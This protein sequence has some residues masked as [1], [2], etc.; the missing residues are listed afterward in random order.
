[1]KK[2]V[3]QA[4]PVRTT[5]L[6]CAIRGVGHIPIIGLAEHRDVAIR[7]HPAQKS[8]SLSCVNIEVPVNGAIVPFHEGRESQPIE[9]SECRANE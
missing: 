1:M 9:D 3:L 7:R 4:P 6:R 2:P 8:A 5:I